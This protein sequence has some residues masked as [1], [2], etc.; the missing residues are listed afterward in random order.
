MILISN[1]FILHN[2][3]DFL[4]SLS[5]QIKTTNNSFDGSWN[6]NYLILKCVFEEDKLLQ[7][8]SMITS[9]LV[10]LSKTSHLKGNHFWNIYKSKGL[11]NVQLLCK[12]RIIL[13][14]HNL[15]VVL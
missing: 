1:K 13:R 6:V 14:M 15:L 7:E 9:F 5:Y 4:P 3:L 10:F 2:T 12:I 11:Y 8:L